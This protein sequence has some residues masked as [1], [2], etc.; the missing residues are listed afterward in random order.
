MHHFPAD[1][2][3]G[4][5]K[6]L[7]VPERLVVI[8]G[9]I[10][11]PGAPFGLVEYQTHDLAVDGRPVPSRFLFPQIEDVAHQIE[12]VAFAVL[13]EVKEIFGLGGAQALVFG[14]CCIV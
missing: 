4:E 2:D 5:V 11:H 6:V 9:H 7:I 10:G 13:E 3:A 8:A 12:P 14:Y 1:V